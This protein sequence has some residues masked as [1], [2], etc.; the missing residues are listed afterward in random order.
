MKFPQ[1]RNSYWAPGCKG[2]RIKYLLQTT[3]LGKA[4][5]GKREKKL[6]NPDYKAVEQ[7]FKYKSL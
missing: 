4:Y 6:P 3:I 2:F 7:I 5:K 1:K